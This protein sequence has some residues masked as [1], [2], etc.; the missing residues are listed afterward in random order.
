VRA[1]ADV[2]AGSLTIVIQFAPGTL[3]RQTTRA[4]MLSDRDP[5]R[6]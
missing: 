5:S 4:S 2:A 3:D 6:L 1:T